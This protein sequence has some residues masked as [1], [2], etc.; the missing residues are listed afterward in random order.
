LRE[1]VRVRGIKNIQVN[2]KELRK[3]LTAAARKNE[4]GGATFEIVS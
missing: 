4:N 3:N 1:R 2:A